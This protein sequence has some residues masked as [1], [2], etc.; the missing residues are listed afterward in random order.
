MRT[1]FEYRIDFETQD[2]HLYY[3]VIRRY[4]I[5]LIQHYSDK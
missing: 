4:V 1:Q 2:F 3:S 5:P